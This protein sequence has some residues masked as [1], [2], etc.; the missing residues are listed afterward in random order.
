ML[1][2]ARLAEPSLQ[3]LYQDYRKLTEVP[4]QVAG[5]PALERR[6][7]GTTEGRFWTGMAIYF[8]R[9]REYFTLLGVTA[10]DETVGFQQA[11]LRKVVNSLAFFPQEASAAQSS[12]LH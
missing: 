5:L 10:A 9:G 7:T 6:F 12:T 2:Y 11:I 4:T 3:G 8:A 1:S